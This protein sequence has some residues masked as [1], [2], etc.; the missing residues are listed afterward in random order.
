MSCIANDL[1]KL[2]AN[3][4]MENTHTIKHF[5]LNKFIAS[6]A[7]FNITINSYSLF[8]NF[9][10]N[11]FQKIQKDLGEF[12]IPEIRRLCMKSSIITKVS[13]VSFL[14]GE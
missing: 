9:E 11:H 2:G 7:W 13:C 14:M 10:K 8:F 6:V 4:E 1:F 12:M 5:Q 3:I